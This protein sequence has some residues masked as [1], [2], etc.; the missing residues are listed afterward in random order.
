MA[1]SNDWRMPGIGYVMLGT[2]DIARSLA[3]YR[4]LSL[5]IR[6]YSVLTSFRKFPA[7]LS[8]TPAPQRC[9]SASSWERR[10]KTWQ[11]RLKWFSLWMTST[12]HTSA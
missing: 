5:F 2:A 11:A 12:R 4:S 3:L 1:A 9:D 7:L 10:Q 6:I 8:S